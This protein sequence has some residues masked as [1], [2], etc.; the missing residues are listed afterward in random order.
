MN[1]VPSSHGWLEVRL[2]LFTRR[3]WNERIRAICNWRA[4]SSGVESSGLLLTRYMEEERLRLLSGW[5]LLLSI[6]SVRSIPTV[7]QQTNLL[8][9]SLP[10]STRQNFIPKA[11]PLFVPHNMHVSLFGWFTFRQTIQSHSCCPSSIMLP[12]RRKKG[13]ILGLPSSSSVI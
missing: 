8:V 9:F 4:S 6:S 12:M 2:T 7:R 13:R 11:L 1:K 3:K 5:S 10:G